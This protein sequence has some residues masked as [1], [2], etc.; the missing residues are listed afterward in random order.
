MHDRNVHGPSP[1]M[2]STGAGANPR[3]EIKGHDICHF[4]NSPKG[5]RKVCAF[6]VVGCFTLAISVLNDNYK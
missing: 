6:I 2:E 1:K 3:T 5:G 4:R